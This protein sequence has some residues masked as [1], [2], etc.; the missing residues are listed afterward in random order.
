MRASKTFIIL[1]VITV[2]VVAAA[3]FT[4]RQESTIGRAGEPL[5]PGLDQQLQEAAK[6]VATSAGEVVNLTREG[7]AW[8]VSER[9]G[10]AANQQEITELLIGTASLKRVEPKTA[11]PE[12]YET[13]EV[14]DPTQEDSVAI[15]YEILGADDKRLASYVMG[16]RRIGKTDPTREEYFIRVADDPQVWLVAGKL[17]RHR[18]ANA[19]LATELINFDQ[20]RIKRVVVDHT[21]GERIE[22]LK[23]APE[24]ATFVLTNIPD[25]REIDLDYRVHSVATVL[26]QLNL[27][28]VKPAGEVDFSD[29]ELSATLET[30][31]GLR[32]NVQTKKVDERTYLTF[33]A[34]F[35]ERLVWTGD[36]PEA[37]AAEGDAKDD[38]TPPPLKLLSVDDVKAEIETLNAGTEQWAYEVSTFTI[39]NL[40]KRMAELTKEIAPSEEATSEEAKKPDG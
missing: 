14:D 39:D 22:V 35:D 34:A 23:N 17:P 31:D 25:D 4:P 33:D 32:M 26:S 18:I 30:F 16:K 11:K 27:E 1:A 37:A 7:D 20:R 28:D 6:I 10:Y 15:Q 24:E 36:L 29:N 9:A 13:L 21:D 38:K 19:W 5:F 40:R 8:T 3:Y 2:A 12:N